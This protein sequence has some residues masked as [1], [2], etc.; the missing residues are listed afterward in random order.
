MRVNDVENPEINE[1]RSIKELTKKIDHQLESSLKSYD[2][3]QKYGSLFLKEKAEFDILSAEMNSEIATSKLRE[4]PAFLGFSDCE[5]EILNNINNAFASTYGYTQEGFFY[6][7][8]PIIPPRKANK[9]KVTFFKN[10]LY[11]ILGDAF[12]SG[13]IQ[14]HFFDNV[15]IVYR[16]RYSSEAKKMYWFDN[17]NMEFSALTNILAAFFLYDDSPDICD[18]FIFSDMGV[19]TCTEAYI[20]PKEKFKEFW[21][22]KENGQLESLKLLSEYPILP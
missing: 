12:S 19:E 14:R 13:K 10:T 5:K 7:K 3:F 15:V 8:I 6:L 21:I 16:N 2:E 4:L 22:Q 18:L 1:I 11:T 9:E 20:V 17:D